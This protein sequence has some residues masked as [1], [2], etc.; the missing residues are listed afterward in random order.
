MKIFK[1]N[2]DKYIRKTAISMLVALGIVCCS[3]VQAKAE[4]VTP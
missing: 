1:K 2:V 3:D 4:Y